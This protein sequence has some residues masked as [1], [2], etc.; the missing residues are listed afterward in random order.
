[1][2]AKIKKTYDDIK[3]IKIQGATNVARAVGEALLTFVKKNKDK[4]VS[5]LIKQSKI[6]ARYLLSAR[7]TEPMAQNIVEYWDFLLSENESKKTAEWLSFLQSKFGDFLLNI[8]KNERLL[9]ALGADLVSVNDKVFTHCHSSTVIKSL[10]E[11]KKQKKKF[12]VFQT[13]T[14]P[15]YQGHRTAQDLL[16]NKINDTLVV[17]SAASYL[18]SSYSNEK[19]NFDK[20]F[21]GCDSIALDGSC[22]NKV[23]SF[24]LAFSAYQNKVPVYV[25]TQSLKLNEDAHTYRQ[26]KIEKRP[27][28]EVWDKAPKSLT[29][30]NLAFD[31][32][33]AEFITGYVTEL[34]ILSP[35][36]LA[37]KIIKNYPWL[38][39]KK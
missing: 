39:L 11:A 9:V 35:S 16:K 14:R 3:S 20:V 8:D 31:L 37:P 27:A 36:E 5:E 19:I 12:Q 13:E 15:L 29:I 22:V 1:M 26:I 24:A 2:D 34:G 25:F 17:D 28:R 18:L 6:N 23:G 10:L 38:N 4:K 7:V 30:L 21:L 32:V 33:P